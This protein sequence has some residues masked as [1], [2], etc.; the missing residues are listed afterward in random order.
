MLQQQA[1]IHSIQWVKAK[2]QDMRLT[3]AVY[4]ESRVLFVAFRNKKILRPMFIH[5]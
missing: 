1:A 5:V 3:G 4:P 2:D